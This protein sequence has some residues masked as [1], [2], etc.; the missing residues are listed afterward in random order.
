MKIHCSLVSCSAT[1][2]AG[3]TSILLLI[4]PDIEDKYKASSGWNPD[5]PA[6]VIPFIP[7]PPHTNPTF[8][9]EFGKKGSVPLS[10]F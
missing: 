4:L 5:P 6:L 3:T 10:Y 7:A 8:T 9:V 1:M 2:Q